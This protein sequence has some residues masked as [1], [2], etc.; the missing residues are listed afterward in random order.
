MQYTSLL[1]SCELIKAMFF[2]SFENL[3]LDSIPIFVDIFLAICLFVKR[4][5]CHKLSSLT[6]IMIIPDIRIAIVTLF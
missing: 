5:I 6:K 1:P 2:P 3:G 4:D